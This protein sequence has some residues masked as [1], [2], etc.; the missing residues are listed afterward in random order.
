MRRAVILFAV[1]AAVPSMAAAQSDEAAIRKLS[2]DFFAAWSRNDVKALTATF[3]D[4]ADLIN[5]FG[6]VAKGHAE[7]EKLLT[8]EHA[9]PFKGTKYEATVTLRMLAP[10]IALGDWDATVTGMHDPSGKELPPFK[11]HVAAVYI[12]RGAQWLAAAA[13]PY[14]FLPPPPQ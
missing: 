14:A 9:G 3:A 1:L 10:T 13:R 6:R 2:N 11:H 8:E 5:P 12:K 7:I 4:D